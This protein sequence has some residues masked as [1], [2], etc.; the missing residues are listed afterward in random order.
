MTKYQTVQITHQEGLL[1][2]FREMLDEWKEELISELRT[3][4]SLSSFDDDRLIQAGDAARRLGISTRTLKR[5]RDDN[6]IPFIQRGNL[7]LYSEKEI[8]RMITENYH[9][10]VS[11]VQS[12][13]KRKG[14]PSNFRI[15]L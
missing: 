12:I 2:S 1:K 10:N 6:K 8:Q 7:F 9:P 11:E 13:Q 14:R 15:N 5:Y 4:P 3:R